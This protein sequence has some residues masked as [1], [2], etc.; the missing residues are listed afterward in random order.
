MKEGIAFGAQGWQGRINEDFTEENIARVSHAFVRYLF[1]ISPSPVTPKAAIGF[2]G[3]KNSKECASLVA[4]VLAAN[5]VD[6]LL[7]SGVVPTAVLSFATRHNSCTSG[8]MVTGGDNP[9]EYNGMEFKGAYG[10]PFMPAATA[11]LEAFLSDRSEEPAGSTKASCKEI[12]LADFLPAYKSHLETLVDFSALRSFA[13]DPKNTANVLI[14]S[15]GGTGQTI[16]EDILVSCGWRAQTLFGTPE[17]RFFDRRPESVSENIDALKYNVKVVDAQFGVATDGSGNRCGIVYDEGRWMCMQETMLAL[18][19]HMH[20]Q[21]HWQGNILTSAYVTGRI[22]SLSS[23]W[24]IPHLDLGLENGVEEMCKSAFLIGAI[25]SGGFCFGRHLPEC[26]GILSGLFFAEM[27]AQSGKPLREIIQHLRDT[28]GQVYYRSVDIGYGLVEARQL[29]ANAAKS[30]PK[31]LIS[32]RFERMEVLEFGGGMKGTQFKLGDC[33]WLLIEH[34][35]FKSIF[36]LHCEG[37]SEED[38]SAILEWGEKL[39]KT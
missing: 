5:G 29:I 3:R 17:D 22:K 2:D 38:V 15:M 30:P 35:P 1:Q 32:G 31:S 24:N 12:T 16:I 18:L 21:K 37:E 8:I 7:S 25:G 11:K 23:R 26:D 20:E 28:L 36:R 9:S 4:R 33:R 27:I 39:F 13:Q 10:G 19:W 34:L 14:D 6:T